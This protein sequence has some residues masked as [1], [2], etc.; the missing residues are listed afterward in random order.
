[1]LFEARAGALPL[2]DLARA[3]L[4]EELDRPVQHAPRVFLQVGH[5]RRE[6]ATDAAWETGRPDVHL[7]TENAHRV[8]LDL[9]RGERLYDLVVEGDSRIQPAQS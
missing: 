3:G 5:C 4:Y 1:M 6:V 9:D 8:A 7:P 2:H